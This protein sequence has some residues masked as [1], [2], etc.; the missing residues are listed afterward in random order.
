MPELIA[1][2]HDRL[3]PVSGEQW[4]RLFPGH[5]DPFELV[6]L[7]QSC[8][9]DGF[10]F[11][12][13]V[14]TDS[15]SLAAMPILLI[16]LFDVEFALHGLLDGAAATIV[17]ALS[18]LVRSPFHPRLLGVGFVEGEWGAVGIDPDA[19]LD[20]LR[21][22]WSLALAELN[23]LARRISAK[24]IVLLSFTPDSARW[25]PPGPM[26]R[27][28]RIDTFPCGRLA[29]PFKNVEAYLSSL[30]K[31][32]RKDLRR[33]Q[34]EAESVRIQ[35]TRDPA[36]W[37][38]Q[39]EAL[40]RSTVERADMSFGAHRRT[41]FLRACDAVPGAEYVFYFLGDRLLA[42]NLLVR[43]G[44]S[45]V[46]KYFCADEALGRK[47]NLYFISW[48]ENVRYCVASGIP[49]YHAGPGAEGTKARLGA[50]FLPSLTLFRHTNP[51][52]HW[53]LARLRPL[54]AY[55]PAI[56]VPAAT[57]G[58]GWAGETDRSDDPSTAA[59]SRPAAQCSPSRTAA[60]PGELKMERLASSLDAVAVATASGGG[61]SCPR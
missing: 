26:S 31:N 18:R 54:L 52:I 22:A 10:S 33:K 60:G 27:F 49:V 40:Y 58:T 25:L 59:A 15:D 20:T 19:P 9:M 24:V 35:R 39:I 41:F 23:A 1:H 32:A 12:S 28:A 53:A 50:Q 45:L 6:R 48:V 21:H 13:I 3:D 55:R 29:L 61:A 14:V 11:R 5:P 8:G 37:I 34:R 47:Y 16:P 43:Q 4:A 36:A 38:D 51:V 44:D 17:R 42:F 46:D 7:V 30:S 2:V 57:L 56:D